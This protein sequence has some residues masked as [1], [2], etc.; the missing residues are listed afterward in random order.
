MWEEEQEVCICLS[1]EKR[2]EESRGR[3]QLILITYDLWVGWENIILVIVV[4]K[5]FYSNSI[6]W[7]LSDDCAA[8][9]WVAAL[10]SDKEGSQKYA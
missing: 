3:I 2:L 6:K 7:Q 1:E 9:K 10:K 5:L 8:L 4:S